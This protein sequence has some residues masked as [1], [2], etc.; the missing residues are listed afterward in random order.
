G[1]VHSHELRRSR[2]DGD[3]DDAGVVGTP[4]AH[5]ALVGEPD[6]P[7]RLVELPDLGAVADHARH[8]GHGDPF[9]GAVLVV[10]EV[11]VRVRDDLGQP[12]RGFLADEPE[13]RAV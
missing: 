8:A 4:V 3:Q 7:G 11:D 6:L 13:V 10:G 1:V 9:A 5:P 12:G 2:L